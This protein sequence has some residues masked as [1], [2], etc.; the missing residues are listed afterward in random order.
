MAQN[1]TVNPPID[2]TVSAA[3]ALHRFGLGPRS[4]SVAAIAS[5]VRGALLAELDRP[6]AGHIDSPD[7]LTSGIAARTAFAFKRERRTARQVE[8]AAR[9]ANP[10]SAGAGDSPQA[11]M[12]PTEQPAA[13]LGAKQGPGVPQQ[14][15]LDEAKARINAALG[16]EIGFAERLVWF[17]SNHFCV[18]ADKGN[19]RQLCGAYEREAIR[20][21]VLGRFGEMLLAAESHP[22]MLL[23]LDNARSIGPDS[24][25]GVRR[26]RGLNEN[27]AREILELHTLGVRTVYSQDDVTRFANVITGWTVIAP[28]QDPSRIG[29]FEFNPNM[30]QPGAQSVIGKSYP[31]TGVEQGRA[32]LAAL[33]RHPATAQH[34]ATKLARHFIADD[35]PPALVA[36]LAKRFLDTQGDLKEVAKTLVN[37][38]EA[39]EAPRTKLKRPGEWIIGSLRAAGVTPSEVGPVMQAHNLLGEPLW[40]PSAPKGFADD[41]ASW[42]DGLAQRVDLANQLARRIGGQADPREVFEQTLAPL[43]STDTRQAIAR[44]ESR[45]QAFALLFM[46]PEFQR[47]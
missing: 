46:S 11:M 15:Y 23:Y 35:P 1:P 36:R 7:L 41:S 32:V 34:V 20:A 45:P 47:R 21:N 10:Q 31:D 18:S 12:N 16:A 42:L 9:E 37:S 28:R 39:W 8:R 2:P 22:A 30:H 17:W 29:E 44:A 6:G 19:V 24:I 27:L 25:A 13:P 43:A 3:L 33:A 4:G 38:P 5:D 26:A 40:R 14:I